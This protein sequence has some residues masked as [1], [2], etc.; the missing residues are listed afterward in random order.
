MDNIIYGIRPVTEAVKQGRE[1]DKILMQ[2]NLSGDNIRQLK[3]QLRQCGRNIKIQYV[4]AE[5]LNAVTKNA[6]HQGVVAYC[7]LIEYADL[8]QTLDNV[9]S[10][11]RKPFILFL[12]GLTDVRN[13]GAVIR[14]AE[15]AGVDCVIL[16]TEGS[17]QINSDAVKTSAGAV[18]RIPV[19]KSVNTKTTLNFL[20]QS[21]IKLYSASEKAS[22]IYT[23]TDMTEPLCIIMGSE[24]KGVSSQ[25]LKMSDELIKIPMKG[26][27]ESLNVSVAAGVIIYE[28]I[29]QRQ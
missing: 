1:I 19:C 13:L 16:P 27:I 3:E 28:V 29:R 6:N 20:R 18:L 17:A 2:S 7:S 26:E 23:Q 4:P 11:G 22:K 8:E 15:C 24:N 14:T 10:Q 12:D 9:F 25:S 21:G 5:K